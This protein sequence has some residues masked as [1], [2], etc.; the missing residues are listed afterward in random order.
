M[1]GCGGFERTGV[2]ALHEPLSSF[3]DRDI[4]PKLG[5]SFRN[6]A[7]RHNWCQGDGDTIWF[8]AD[9]ASEDTPGVGTGHACQ[10]LDGCFAA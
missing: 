9:A 10:A 4:R 6:Y 5:P 2:S 8:V 7:E 1:I 3:G